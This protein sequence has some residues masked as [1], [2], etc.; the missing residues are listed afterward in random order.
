MKKFDKYFTI[1]A[2]GAAVASVAIIF[3]LPNERPAVIADVGETPP[4]YAT[5]GSRSKSHDAPTVVEGAVTVRTITPEG[6]LSE[7]ITTSA[8]VRSPA[9]WKKHLSAKQYQ[10]LREKGTERAF[11]GDLLEN[12]HEGIYTCAGCKLPLFESKTKFESGTGWPS[13]YAPIAKENV[14]EISDTSYGM[15]RTEVVCARCGG[16]LGHVFN[17][18]PDPTGLRYCMNSVSLGF[19]PAD[20][21]NELAEELVMLAKEDTPMNKE[22]GMWLPFPEKDVPLAAEPGEAKAIFA[23]GCFW[24]TEAVFE[25]LEGVKSVVSGYTG[26]DPKQANYKAVCT[27]NTGHAEAIEIVYDPAKITYGAL[28]RVFFTTHDPTTLNRQGPDS[29]TQYRSAI[30]YQDDAEKERAEAYIAQLNA[31]GKFSSPV[32][33]TLEPLEKFFVAEDY[34]QDYVKHNPSNPYI[35]H[36]ALPKVKKLHKMLEDDKKAGS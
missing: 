5:E 15:V 17:D 34:H 29:G 28:M 9:E 1:A 31:S 14:T 10:V 6:A 32:V 22:S 23:G 8:V 18:G 2:V 11:T 27:G 16:H 7:P 26:G 13:Y 36:N 30:F 33:T 25:E 3:L 20:K 35:V 24:C 4:S 12:K 19:T 21:I